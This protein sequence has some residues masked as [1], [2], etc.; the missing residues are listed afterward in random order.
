MLII[1]KNY[2]FVGPDNGVLLAAAKDDGIEAII[3]LENEMYFR[4]PVSASFHGRD[5][6]MPV[7][8]WL[9]CGVPPYTFGKTLSIYDVR[10]SPISMYMH[11]TNDRCV[12]L[13]VVHIDKFG[14]VTLSHFYEEISKALK[15]SLGDKVT[16]YTQGVKAE[17][18]V[19][20]VFSVVEE[21]TLV[22]YENSFG[23]AELAVN[24]GS[25][26]QVLKVSRRDYVEICRV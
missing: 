4:K 19:E 25:A 15:V 23:L 8:A 14:N 2:Y 1:T 6:F 16:V 17:A 26:Q 20:R 10:D 24:K 18:R 22:L 7:A 3:E 5:I 9:A 12:K 21:G 13:R 11:K